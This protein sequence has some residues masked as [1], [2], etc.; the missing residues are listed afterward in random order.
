MDIDYINCEICGI[1]EHPFL[2]PEIIPQPTLA[3]PGSIPKII[4]SLNKDLGKH[5]FRLIQRLIFLRPFALLLLLQ[6]C[7]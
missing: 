3:V 6:P 5:L 1:K 7:Y 2:S 4:I